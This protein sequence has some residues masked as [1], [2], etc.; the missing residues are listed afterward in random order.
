MMTSE[1]NNYK[2]ADSKIIII[3]IQKQYRIK[4]SD[5]DQDSQSNSD[6][7]VSVL[8]GSISS[9]EV[10]VA[11]RPR[12]LTPKAKQNKSWILI[13]SNEQ[14][15]CYSD[16]EDRKVEIAHQKSPH[17]YICT[18]P[19]QIFFHQQFDQSP[20]VMNIIDNISEGQIAQMQEFCQSQSS[21]YSTKIVLQK[22]INLQ[23][24]NQANKDLVL[25]NFVKILRFASNLLEY[26]NIIYSKGLYKRDES[27]YKRQYDS[28]IKYYSDTIIQF[29]RLDINEQE[30]HRAQMRELADNKEKTFMIYKIQMQ[31]DEKSIKSDEFRDTDSF[32]KRTITIFI[33]DDPSF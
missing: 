10:C 28:A 12:V 15:S 5:E 14:Q 30:K 13:I 21:K 24:E 4:M 20:A 25:E 6:H 22:K 7:S 2:K 9:T 32:Q 26:I 29:K 19:Q 27:Y 31:S 16:D 3:C 33:G 18:I 23:E 8:Q 11:S 1:D 17:F